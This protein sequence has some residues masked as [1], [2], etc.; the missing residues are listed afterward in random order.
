MRVGVLLDGPS[1]EREGSL[2]SGQA[3]AQALTELGHIPVALSVGECPSLLQALVELDCVFI[4]LHGRFGEDGRVQGLL[5]ILGIPYTGSGVAAN[6]V[7]MHKVL[8]KRMLQGAGLPTP[9]FVSLGTGSPASEAERVLRVL[10]PPVI[11]KPVDGG[12]SL[13][14]AVASDVATLASAI[15]EIR[16]QFR[17]LFVEQYIRGTFLTVGLVGTYGAPHAFPVMEIRHPGPVYDY[18]TKHTPAAAE[19]VVPAQVPAAAY[20]AAEEYARRVYVLLGCHGPLRVD[21]MLESGQLPWVIEA[22]TVPGLSRQG[23]LPAVAAA[24]G[25]CYHELISSILSSAFSKS[26][27]TLPKL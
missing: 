1:E 24:G 20:E 23:N 26:H 9:P 10:N 4:A 7:G 22:N 14:V 11:L 17:E 8:F 18:A 6:A 19:Y 27:A 2:R 16:P 12:G 21:F 15:S 13:G 25:M 5:D 3:V